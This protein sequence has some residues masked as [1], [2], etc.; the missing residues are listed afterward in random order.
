[1]IY[2]NIQWSKLTIIYNAPAKLTNQIDNNIQWYTIIYNA[3][4]KLT[5]IYNDPNWQ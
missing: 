1:M 5:I 2:N 4:A 3:L